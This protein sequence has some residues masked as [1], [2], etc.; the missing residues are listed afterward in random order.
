MMRAD[1]SLHADQARWYVGKPHFDLAAKP[2]LPQ[3]NRSPL[4][5]TRDVERVLA[6]ID[7]DD[8]DYSVDFLR[9]GMLLV[10]AATCQLTCWTIPLAALRPSHTMILAAR[11]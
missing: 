6:D 9:R 5:E 4:I 1:T 10:F 7:A 11:H 3:H 8:R 2:F